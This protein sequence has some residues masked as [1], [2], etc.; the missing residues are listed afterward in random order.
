MRVVLNSTNLPIKVS[1]TP[2]H[3]PAEDVLVTIVHANSV[4]A[5]VEVFLVNRAGNLTALASSEV[6]GKDDSGSAVGYS[7][8]TLRLFVSESD[9]IPNSS[10][11]T[12]KLVSYDFPG[13]LPTN[14]PQTAVDTWARERLTVIENKLAAIKNV[15]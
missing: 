8:G 14:Q 10:G 15:L 4:P 3:N 13:A 11:T 2:L 9:L 7:D 5:R 6:L 1:A 12:S